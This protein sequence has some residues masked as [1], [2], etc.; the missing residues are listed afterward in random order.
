MLHF[1]CDLCGQQLDDERFVVKM[2][3]YPA[4]DPEEICEEDLSDDHLEE[5]AEILKQAEAEGKVE[6]DDCSSKAFRFDLCS[7]CRRRF[8]ADPLGR[9]T[10]A[11]FDFSKN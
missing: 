2:E 3:V 8:I 1:S 11:R 7:E 9:E 4:F 5:V 10:L 6:L